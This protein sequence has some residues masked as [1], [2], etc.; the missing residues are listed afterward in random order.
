MF[1]E[2]KITHVKGDIMFRKIRENGE[3]GTPEQKKGILEYLLFA[4]FLILSINF[5]VILSV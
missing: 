5:F 1:S 4:A 3:W 2:R